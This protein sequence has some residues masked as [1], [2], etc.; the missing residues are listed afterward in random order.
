MSE[1]KLLPC[2][3]CGGEARH[4]TI[5]GRSGIVCNDCL[6]EMRGWIDAPPEEMTMLWNTR[7]PMDKIVERL[8]QIKMRYFLT[9]ANTGDENSDSIY[10][11]VGN[12]IDKAIKIIKE[13][14]GV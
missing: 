6:C 10:E 7:K 2:P 13:E 3:F 11:E 14:G 4:S 1:I 8:E 9:I 12:A 5:F